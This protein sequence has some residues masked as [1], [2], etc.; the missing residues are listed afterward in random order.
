M[1]VYNFVSIWLEYKESFLYSSALVGNKAH[2]QQKFVVLKF[3]SKI[4]ISIL[5]TLAIILFFLYIWGFILE[6]SM[7]YWKALLKSAFKFLIQDDAIKFG[8]ITD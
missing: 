3:L 7:S 8:S 6:F 2:V 4:L 1:N 5:Y